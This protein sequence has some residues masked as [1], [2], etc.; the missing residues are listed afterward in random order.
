VKYRVV[1]IATALV[2]LL[3]LWTPPASAASIADFKF[4]TLFG[5][6]SLNKNPGGRAEVDGRITFVSNRKIMIDLW[7][8]TDRCNPAGK[9]DGYGAWTEIQALVQYNPPSGPVALAGPHYGY[10]LAC[11][12]GFAYKYD[13]Q[14]VAPTDAIIRE[15]KVFLCEGSQTRGCSQN[16]RDYAYSRVMDNPYS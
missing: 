3:G 14:Y 8:L 1:A 15:V 13:D 11:D 7:E 12:G 10:F 5:G 4:N 9:N 6:D 2:S 16:A